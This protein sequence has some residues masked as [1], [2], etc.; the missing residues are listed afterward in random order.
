M[1]WGPAIRNSAK[2]IV[3][4]IFYAMGL[5]FTLT[6]PQAAAARLL[7]HFLQFFGWLGEFYPIPI[8]DIKM[9]LP[10]PIRH[11]FDNRI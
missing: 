1:P 10:S 2:I 3:D 5:K 6:L 8:T 11:I 9:T 7:I 4:K